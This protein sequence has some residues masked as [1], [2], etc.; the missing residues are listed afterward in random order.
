MLIL[1]ARE[2][3]RLSKKV[4]AEYLKVGRGISWSVEMLGSKVEVIA[5]SSNT[6]DIFIGI[7]HTRGKGPCSS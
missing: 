3:K 5:D 4:K 7:R 6:D 2:V 1:E